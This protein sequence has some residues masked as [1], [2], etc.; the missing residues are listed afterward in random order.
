MNI[1]PCV[2]LEPVIEPTV[3]ST[4]ELER[5]GDQ[6]AELPLISTPPVRGSSI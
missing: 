6:I 4:A 1:A 3:S 2:S 5:L